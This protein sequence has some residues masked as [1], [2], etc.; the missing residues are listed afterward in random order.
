MTAARLAIR[1]PKAEERGAILSVLRD[2]FGQEDEARMVETLWRA[3]AA[4]PELIAVE[5][6]EIIGYCAFSPA[7]A[8]PP[9]K[10]R[11]LGLAPVGVKTAHQNRGVGAALVEQGLK[12]CRTRGASLV[13]V[14]GHADYY[15]RFGFAPASQK[16]V[17]WADGD[18]GDAFQ[19]IDIA[20]VADGAPCRI[21]YHPAFSE[22]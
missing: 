5:N 18:A 10:G 8:D 4:D 9:L 21:S 13:V 3:G 16:N 12:D 14:L 15:P 17:A 22:G 11:L 19:L 1:A 20:G 7:T 2:A 6:G